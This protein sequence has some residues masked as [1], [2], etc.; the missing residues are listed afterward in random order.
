MSEAFEYT[1]DSDRPSFRPMT[2]V[3]VFSFTILRS[4]ALSEADHAL[5]EF[6]VDLVVIGYSSV[7]SSRLDWVPMNCEP[8]S[9]IRVRLFPG[10]YIAWG[11]GGPGRHSPAFF[12]RRLES[13]IQHR[14]SQR[15]GMPDCT[16]GQM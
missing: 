2:R 15:C 9:H 3:G 14:Q 1:A 6:R 13:A 5:P 12:V 10:G 7:W 8:R 16:G 11:H 4:A